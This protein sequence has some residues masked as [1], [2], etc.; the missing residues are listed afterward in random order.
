M[1]KNFSGSVYC[2]RSEPTTAFYENPAMKKLED[3]IESAG[4]KPLDT[5]Q[6]GKC[7]EGL[8]QADVD[9]RDGATK[10]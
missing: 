4:K 7:H 1:I 10:G 5:H 2:N 9:G 6:Q 8:G 3:S